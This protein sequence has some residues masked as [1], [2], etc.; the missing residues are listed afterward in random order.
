MVARCVACKGVGQVPVLARPDPRV[1]VRRH[2]MQ[3]IYTLAHYLAAGQEFIA[4][5]EKTFAE[6][7]ASGATRVTITVTLSA[8]QF[9]RMWQEVGAKKG[10]KN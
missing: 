3:T 7:P 1:S 5:D 6:K 4:W 10:W 9:H 2:R 8:L